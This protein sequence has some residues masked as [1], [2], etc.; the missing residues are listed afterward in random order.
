M[1]KLEI[2]STKSAF[3]IHDTNGVKL[4]ALLISNFSHLNEHLHCWPKY[5]QML[6]LVPHC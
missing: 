6:S 4:I 5:L 3:A 1:K 2:Y